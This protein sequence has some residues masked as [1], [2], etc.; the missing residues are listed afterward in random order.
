MG[1]GAGM[2]ALLVIV[3]ALLLD[4]AFG[5]PKRFHPLVAFGRL[6]HAVEQRLY[7]AQKFRGVLAVA[8]LITPFALIA[9]LARFTVV[10]AA[11][12][13]IVL[14]L[15]IGRR[16]LAAHA[17]PVRESLHAGNL[18][19]ARERVGMMVSRDTTPMQEADVSKATV[20]S[21]LENGNDAIFGAIFWFLIAGA[22]GA[23]AYRLA[24]TLDAMWGYRNARYREFGWAA[25]RLDDV[26]NF[27]PARL[28]ALSYA[29]AG[30]IAGRT[31]AALRCWREQGR[32]WKSPNAG[33][34]MAAGAGS[35]GLTLGGSA[36]YHGALEQRP[37]L[38]SG[39]APRARD[40]DRALTLIDRSLAIWLI[41]LGGGTLLVYAL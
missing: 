28:T 3:A 5:E 25:A 15:A 40:I 11:L 16:S 20:E 34:V 36:W 21:V 19:K 41:A 22:P 24:N 33:P 27:V 18:S 4:A 26:L 10:G 14:Y 1:A 12:D 8:I 35:L 29:L 6:A 39:R 17:L 7:R 37:T 9:A 2:T 31:H 30:A 23:L 13:V 38:G 32:R